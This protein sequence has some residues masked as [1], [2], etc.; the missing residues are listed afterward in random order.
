MMMMLGLFKFILA[1]ATK[2]LLYIV[3]PYKNKSIDVWFGFIAY[4]LL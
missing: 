1:P 2:G 3:I 4:Q